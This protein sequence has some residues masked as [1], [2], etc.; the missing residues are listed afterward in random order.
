LIEK[1]SEENGKERPEERLE[2][3]AT[4]LVS[5]LKTRKGRKT[6]MGGRC[7]D[8]PPRISESSRQ[9]L[10]RHRTWKAIQDKLVQEGKTEVDSYYF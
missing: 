2:G 6:G 4:A 3:R 5:K 7:K 10:E 8:V 9:E 1:Y